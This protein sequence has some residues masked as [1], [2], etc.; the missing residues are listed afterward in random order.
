ML[1]FKEFKKAVIDFKLDIEEGDIQNI[2]KCF[3]VNGDGVL[4]ISEF[5]E[6]MLG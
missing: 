6:M 3:D 4:D 2:F 1:E 5:M